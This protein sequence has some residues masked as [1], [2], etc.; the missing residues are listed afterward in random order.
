ML[1]DV[2]SW[3]S[4]TASPGAQIDLVIDRRDQTINLCE[5]KYTP[6]PFAIDKSYAEALERKR[7]VFRG[8]TG[9]RK[10]IHLTLVSPR[11]IAPGR[12]QHTVQSVVTLDDLFT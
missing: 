4:T 7:S 6:E 12:Y 11:G 9:T 2:S 3:R 10:D 1:T 5:M 8:E